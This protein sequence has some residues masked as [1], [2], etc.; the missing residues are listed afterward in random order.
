MA[1]FADQEL[2]RGLAHDAGVDAFEPM[3]E[4]AKLI[5]APLG[6]IERV[7]VRSR[8]NAQFLVRRSGAHITLGVATQVQPHPAPVAGAIDRTIDV[9]PVGAA[10]VVPLAIQVVAH[11]LPHPRRRKRVRRSRLRPA[12]QVMRHVVVVPVDDEGEREDA[13]VITEVAIHVGRAFP[14][15]H[16]LEGRRLEARDQPLR[17]CK[18]RNA[19]GADVTAAPRLFAGPFDGVVEVDRFTRRPW[20]RATG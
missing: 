15:N 18:I 8:V 2:Y 19:A 17:H 1:A 9:F 4:E 10:A 3:I 11:V 13:A 5:L 12:E 7:I 14:R 16:R 20:I 6:G